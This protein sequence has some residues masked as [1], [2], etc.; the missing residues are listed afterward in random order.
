MSQIHTV[1]PVPPTP[2]LH[3]SSPRKPRRPL[4][5]LLTRDGESFAT[6]RFGKLL[7]AAVLVAVPVAMLFECLR[8]GRYAD[9]SWTALLMA[10]LLAVGYLA[11]RRLILTVAVAMLVVTVTSCALS[12]NLSTA[13]T[14]DPAVQAH[15]EQERN[16]GLLTGFQD[17]AVAEIDLTAPQP[18]RLAGIGA[19]PDT[20]M[21]VGSVTKAMTGLV[22]AD[23]VRRGEVR[24]DAPVSAYLPD[25]AGSQAGTVTLHELVTHTAGYADFGSETLARAAWSAPI[26]RPFLVA[27]THQLTREI[28]QQKLTARGSFQYSSLGAATAGQAVAAA[29]GMSYPELMRIRLF[30]PLGMTHT[31]IQTSQALVAGGRSRTG[32]PVQPWLFDAY[33]PAGGAVSTS[34]DLAKLATALLDGTAPGMA[35]LDPTTPSLTPDTTFGDFWAVSTGQNGRTVTWHNGQTGGYS[36]YVG[37]DRLHH[38]AVVVLSNIAIP[39]TDGL[40]RDL[41]AMDR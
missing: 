25:L 11:T 1:L 26:G 3:P 2:P 34:T 4:R 19:A 31:A 20:P 13:V 10:V 33:A 6:G 22:I 28:R 9:N 39:A 15:L 16:I 23:A 5:C 8:E 37:L 7:V 30:D 38:K 40:G 24:W 32:L 12:P 41:L 21:E 36:S 14:G 35:A 18:V 29:A 17:V 27:D